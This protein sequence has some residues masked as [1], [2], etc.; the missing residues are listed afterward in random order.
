VAAAEEHEKQEDPKEKVE[1]K[2]ELKVAADRSACAAARPKARSATSGNGSLRP[3][4]LLWTI[5][6]LRAPAG[7]CG[8]D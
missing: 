6:P 1:E 4:H 7:P 2:V 5:D 3:D 8:P